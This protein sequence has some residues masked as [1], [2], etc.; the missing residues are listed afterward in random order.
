MASVTLSTLW[1]SDAANPSQSYALPLSSLKWK[2]TK[3]GDVRTYGGG[4]RRL[5]TRKGTYR[6]ADISLSFADRTTVRLLESWAGR[7]LLFRDPMGRKVYG[8]YLEP[9]IEEIDGDDG[10]S[11]SFT[12]TEVTR[13]E[14]V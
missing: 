10:A 2:T 14:E 9:Q 5:V 7:L 12:I 3:T 6:T 4:R 1:V 11:V 8:V 13:S